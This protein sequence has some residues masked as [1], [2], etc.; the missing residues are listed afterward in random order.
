MP[1]ARPPPPT[2]AVLTAARDIP[3][4]SVVGSG[5]LM[6]VDFAPHS[7]PEGVVAESADVVGRTTTAPLRSGEPITDARLVQ[8]SLLDG[9]PGSVAAPVRIADAGAV[10]LL[11]IGDRIDIIAAGPEGEEASVVA[12]DVPVI[13]LPREPASDSLNVAGGLIVVAV[14]GKTAQNIAAA[15]VSRL[16]SIVINR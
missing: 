11:R 1:E 16:L 14:P 2:T 10:A 13:S 6:E 4:G 8:G 7:V 3:G 5:D 12:H 15:G 9:Y